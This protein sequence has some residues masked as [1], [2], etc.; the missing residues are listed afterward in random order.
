MLPHYQVVLLHNGA[1][2]NVAAAQLQG[3]QLNN[4][5]NTHCLTPD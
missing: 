2:G 4:K 3:P 5:K 1:V